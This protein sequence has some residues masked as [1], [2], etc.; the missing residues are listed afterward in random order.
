VTAAR[1]LALAG[2]DSGPPTDGVLEHLLRFLVSATGASAAFIVGA[3]GQI[4]ALFNAN[5]EA[6]GLEIPFVQLPDE[7]R[8]LLLRGEVIWLS[9]RDVVAVMCGTVAIVFLIKPSASER[10]VDMVAAEIARR[11]ARTLETINP[12]A[13]S[14]TAE[15]LSALFRVFSRGP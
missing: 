3:D 10:R 7:A 12:D 8:S 9:E 5:G 11:I 14:M 6:E 4:P 1:R 15:Q 13:E 2:G